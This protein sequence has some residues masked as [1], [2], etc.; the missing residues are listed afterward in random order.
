MI[1]L[2][3]A[4][5]QRVIA[6]ILYSV[7]LLATSLRT[8]GLG[9]VAGEVLLGLDLFLVRPCGKT[10]SSQYRCF[11]FGHACQGGRRNT[12]WW[13]AWVRYA[14]GIGRVWI[15]YGSSMDRG[16][17]RSGPCLPGFALTKNV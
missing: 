13:V 9:D 15:A 14:S 17:D 8:S 7:V 5:H 16:M 2:L 4:F 6:R 10:P 11:G 3:A 12:L 1:S